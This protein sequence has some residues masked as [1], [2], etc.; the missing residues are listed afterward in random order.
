MNARRRIAGLLGFAVWLW[1]ACAPSSEATLQGPLCFRIASSTS[2]VHEY[3]LYYDVS[4]DGHFTIGG[5]AFVRTPTGLGTIVL[6]YPVS[7]GGYTISGGSI[8]AGLRISYVNEG[9]PSAMPFD[10]SLFI[11]GSASA[12]TEQS[13]TTR[14]SYDLDPIACSPLDQM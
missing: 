10:V 7:G 1:L 8:W 14:T 5:R 12:V 13:G 3:R 2:K 4:P 11:A 9:V 6:S